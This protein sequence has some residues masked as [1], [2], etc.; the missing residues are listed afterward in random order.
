MRERELEVIEDFIVTAAVLYVTGG[1]AGAGWGAAA[2]QT[3]ATYAGAQVAIA[4]S[5]GAYDAPPTALGPE[6][7]GRQ[8]TF[9]SPTQPRR[10]LYGQ[11]KVGGT[12]VFIETSSANRYIHIVLAVASHECEEVANQPFAPT[13]KRIFLNDDTLPLS[14]YEND[15]N[16]VPRYTTTAFS[17]ADGVFRDDDDNRLTRFKIYD[18]T[19][20][21][22]DADLVAETSWRDTGV[23]NG[24]AYIYA[25]F[26]WNVDA[27]PR[28]IPSITADVKGKKLYDPR[29]ASHDSADPS[30]WEYSTNP[31]LV[32][33]DY[34]AGDLGLAATDAEID[35]DAVEAAANICDE[36]VNYD[37]LK[38][39]YRISESRYQANGV[40]DAN[41]AP[42]VILPRLLSSMIG[43]CVYS[44]GKWRV[45][46][47]AYRT[48]T[49]TLDED[50]LRGPISV[51]TRTSRRDN[52]NTVKG[53]FVSPQDNYQ[54]TDYPEITSATYVAE[55]NGEKV[56]TELDL[57]FTNSTVAA[58]R[59]A[60]IHLERSR[61]QITINFP[62]KLTAFKLQVGDTVMITNERFGFSSKVFE[63][64][65]W[66]LAIDQA[67]GATAFGINLTLRETA[68]TVFDWTSSE[69]VD[70][71]PAPNTTL[72]NAFDI[73][74]VGVSTSE[75]LRII[76]QKAV[77]V[78]TVDVTGGGVFAEQYE[79][80]FKKSTDSAYKSLG[81][82]EGN[83]FDIVDVEDNVTYDIRARAISNIGVKSNFTTVTHQAVG[84]TA[85]PADVT[86]FRINVVGAEA[87]LSWDPVPDLDL[88]HYQVKHTPDTTAPSFQNA[89]DVV[90]QTSATSVTVPALTGTYLVRAVDTS[91]NVSQNATTVGTDIQSVEGL[92]AVATSTQHPTFAG[93]KTDVVVDEDTFEVPV[94][95]L[96]TAILFD[97]K[98]GD[99]DDATGDFDGGG[100][101]V[102][103]AGTYEFDNYIDLGNRFTSRVTANLDVVRLDYVNLFDD[104]EG[105]FDDRAGLFD[106]DPAAFDDTGVR[107]FVATT[108]DDPAGS[109][110]WS[111]F[112][113][114]VVGDYTARAL[115]FKADLFSEDETATPAIKEMSV[116]VDMPDRVIGDNDIASG[117]AAGGKLVSFSPAFKELQGLAI[118]A[119]NMAT[120]D[121]YDIVSKDANGFTIRFK[122]SGGTVVDRTFDFMAK[123]FGRINT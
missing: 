117:T 3:A 63:V 112:R 90:Q 39:P 81:R 16:G 51:A 106:G 87:H 19:Q 96:K 32:V 22:A 99:F 35:D 57:P 58:Q 77:A 55:D 40:I 115:K 66:T 46:A 50:D 21:Q 92:N 116:A 53:I 103:D 83:L 118:V 45:F 94:L 114:F 108:D 18:G 71:D 11:N 61:Q 76:N 95:K 4:Y 91:G 109:P 101:A 111:S 60:K 28:G 48:P 41:K 64:I 75:E 121:F 113:E 36:T 72:P 89:Q 25:R 2:F 93:T 100:G 105:L 88:S 9:R 79:V 69:Q 59:M 98:T 23:L 44:N 67:E 31:A 68:T 30:T 13:A 56:T 14:T 6:V 52:F 54:P 38:Y 12:I 102:D 10:T 37:G 15:A 73:E 74:D 65:E 29:E 27:F 8:T 43:Q 122:N 5:N 86:N 97:A 85:P 49:I 107:L 26:E 84:K 123:G 20:T 17:Y 120:G 42:N 82:G 47:G 1:I 104:A 62:A 7:Q 70:V 78:I 80:Q 110:T 34:L 119:E 33:R 24:I